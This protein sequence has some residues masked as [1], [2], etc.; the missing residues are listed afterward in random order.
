MGTI[1]AIGLV[2]FWLTITCILAAASSAQGGGCEPDLFGSIGGERVRDIVIQGSVAYIANE[3]GTLLLV[4]VSDPSAPF[5]LGEYPTADRVLS[6]AVAGT[7]AYI[8]VEGVGLQIIDVSEPTTPMYRGGYESSELHG[9]LFVVDNTAYFYDDDLR[10]IAI[11][12]VASP[13]ALTVLGVHPTGRGVTHAVVSD[14]TAFILQGNDLEIV[15]VSVPASPSVLGELEDVARN[16]RAIAIDSSLAYVS[17]L[18]DG[19]AV[20]DISNVTA[21]A[22]LGRSQEPSSSWDV[23]SQGNYAFVGGGNAGRLYVHDISD[24]EHPVIAGGAQTTGSAIAL[25]IEGSTIYIADY[26]GGLQI[27]DISQPL[28]PTSV[29]AFNR[30]DYVSDVVSDGSVAYLSDSGGGLR[31]VDVN[32][33]TRPV[34]MGSAFLSGQGEALAVSSQTAYVWVKPISGPASLQLID[35]SEPGQ[36]IPLGSATSSTT[37]LAVGADG[38]VACI[39]GL[40]GFEV[41]DVSEPMN[42]ERGFTEYGTNNTFYNVDVIGNIAYRCGRIEGFETLDVSNPAEPVLLYRSSDNSDINSARASACNGATAYV[43]AYRTTR[44]HLFTLDVTDPVNVKVLHESEELFASGIT[45]I[46]STGDRLYILYHGGGQTQNSGAAIYDITETQHPRFIEFVHTFNGESNQT[47]N[48]DVID[49]TAYF[50]SGHDGLEIVDLA[51][52]FALA[53]FDSDGRVGSRDLAVVLASWGPNLGA[54]ADLNGD[55]V[56]DLDDLAILLSEWND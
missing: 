1:R 12:D 25:A 8:L 30:T 42:P 33:P 21:P 23:V 4:D 34:L 5:L 3:S 50:A 41:F 29:G 10:G 9:W 6:V 46:K 53:D 49:Q 39:A 32:D 2:R 28:T 35:V 26:F 36:P 45:D 19:I 55:G 43:V 17:D 24:P 14:G 31:V 27:M 18:I 11:V 52:C 56:V 38:D 16:P 47:L 15:D 51:S 54:N 22:L 40:N 7:H 13:G 48:L 37:P 20:V 44:A